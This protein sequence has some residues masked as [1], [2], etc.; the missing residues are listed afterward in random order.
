MK[1]YDNFKDKIKNIAKALTIKYRGFPVGVLVGIAIVAGAS[2]YAAPMLF[3]SK[4]VSKIVSNTLPAQHILQSNNVK[5]PTRNL[6]NNS[7]N[8]NTST[9]H[10]SIPALTSPK[11]NSLPTSNN[12][13]P[14]TT[15]T[16]TSNTP[17]K[18]TPIMTGISVYAPGYGQ[19]VEM[20]IPSCDYETINSGIPE[21]C[22][23]YIPISFNLVATYSDGSTSPL[24]WSDANILVPGSVIIP[25]LFNVNASNSTLIEG[26][27]IGSEW[28]GQSV[29]IPMNIGYQHWSYT[30]FIYVTSAGLWGQ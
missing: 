13:S 21:V 14:S 16:P 28:N 9:N 7:P 20:A 8:V 15:Y 10:S 17:T 23:H 27:S 2:A 30:E 24:S 4:P 18:P 5:Q 12:S 22:H 3:S 6:N 19:T 1:I 26:D 25:N 11:A 29:T